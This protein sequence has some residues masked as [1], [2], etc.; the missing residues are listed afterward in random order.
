MA[1]QQ[2]ARQIRWPIDPPLPPDHYGDLAMNNQSLNYAVAR[3][4]DQLTRIHQP[5]AAAA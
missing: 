2:A 4:E 1:P 5:A 3:W